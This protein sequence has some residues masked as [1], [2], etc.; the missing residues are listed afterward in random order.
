MTYENSVKWKLV[1]WTKNLC[2]SFLK[3][4]PKSFWGAPEYLI[5]LG[6]LSQ[7][8]IK[9]SGAPQKLLGQNLKKLS[10]SFLV[11]ASIFHFNTVFIGPGVKSV[12]MQATE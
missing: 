10:D 6:K 12:R 4:W 2:D 8:L 3:F 11:H 9:Y 7:Y 1:G 5:S